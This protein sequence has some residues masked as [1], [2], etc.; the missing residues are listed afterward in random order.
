MYPPSCQ[1][2]RAITARILGTSSARGQ[3]RDS[4]AILEIQNIRPRII[5]IASHS[6][7]NYASLYVLT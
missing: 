7:L 5:R 2:K 1:A 4:D 3:I 6:N